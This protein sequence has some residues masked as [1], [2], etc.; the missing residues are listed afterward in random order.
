MIDENEAT[1]DS[2]DQPADNGSPNDSIRDIA[3]SLDSLGLDPTNPVHAVLE[4]LT[5][6]L[7]TMTVA[8]DGLEK[9]NKFVEAERKAKV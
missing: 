2:T 9:Q 6:H 8:Q 3:S 1:M 7:S 5:K 4:K